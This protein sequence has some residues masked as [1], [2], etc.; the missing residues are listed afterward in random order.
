MADAPD[1][2][3]DFADLL[4]A[5]NQAS[6][7]F[8]VVGAHALAVHGVVRAT[9]DLDVFVHS[10]EENAQRIAAALRSFGASLAEHGVSEVDFTRDGTVYQLGLPPRRIDIL[11][12][13]SG[14]DFASADT[15]AVDV[16]VNGVPFRV[17]GRRSLLDNKRASGRPKDLED[18]R[19]LES[20]DSE[21]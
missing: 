11:T 13:I 7:E 4:G 1:F 3:D 8:I 16:E 5:L 2:N 15:S 18:V 14:V 10:T 12:S 9:G 17:L 21:E 20:I 19:R 6:V